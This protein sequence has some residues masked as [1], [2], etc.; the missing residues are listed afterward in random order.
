MIQNLCGEITVPHILSQRNAYLTE[1]PR[2][3]VWCLVML[4]GHRLVTVQHIFCE[5]KRDL[6]TDQHA[7]M[8]L[9]KFE[10]IFRQMWPN[11]SEYDNKQ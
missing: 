11:I 5:E 10:N 3:C 1:F 6:H 9:I 4:I 7:I 2:N 8:K